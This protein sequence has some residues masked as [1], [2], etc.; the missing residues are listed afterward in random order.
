M[1]P[2]EHTVRWLVEHDRSIV[3]SHRDDTNRNG[4]VIVGAKRMPVPSLEA[5]GVIGRTHWN[6]AAPDVWRYPA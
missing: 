1:S 4:L 3:Y 6:D 5:D 2:S